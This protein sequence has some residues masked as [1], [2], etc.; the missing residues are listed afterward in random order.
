MRR[1][2]FRI[3]SNAPLWKR[4]MVAELERQLRAARPELYANGLARRL[5]VRR[6]AGAWNQ[7][8]GTFVRARAAEIPEGTLLGA[9]VGDFEDD[10][11]GPYNLEHARVKGPRGAMWIP[12]VNGQL[13]VYQRKAYQAAAYNHTCSRP[14]V[15]FRSFGVGQ[16]K[17]KLAF[18]K[19]RL[20]PNDELVW[21]Y[22]SQYVRRFGNLAVLR[23]EFPSAHACRCQGGQCP[24]NSILIY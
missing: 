10:T 7:G 17:C 1:R 13:E 5:T 15:Y 24:F 20:R 22:G 8:V 11:G 6:G 12:V 4:N 19:R 2:L 14:S 16:L 3:S 23:Q 9:Y 21:N 18:A